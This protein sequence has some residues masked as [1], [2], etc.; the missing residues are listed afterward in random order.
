MAGR[1]HVIVLAR[2]ALFCASVATLAA[3]A[4]VLIAAVFNASGLQ[5]L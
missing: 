3:A 4:E 2:V 1:Y 5:G